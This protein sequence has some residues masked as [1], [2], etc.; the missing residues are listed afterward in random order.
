MSNQQN[1]FARIYGCLAEELVMERHNEYLDC[2]SEIILSGLE[3]TEKVAA[4]F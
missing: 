2:A 1:R 4:V 3:K